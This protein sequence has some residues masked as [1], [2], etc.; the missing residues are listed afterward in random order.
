MILLPNILIEIVRSGG[1]LILDLNQQMFLP[2]FLIQLA[3]EA[4][5]SGATIT[6]KNPKF[7][8]PQ[9]MSD[10]ARAGRGRVIFEL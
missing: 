3:S 10:I 6:I 9:T 7:I 4:A 2:Q 8:M 5:I 1:G